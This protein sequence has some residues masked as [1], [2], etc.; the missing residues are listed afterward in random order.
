MRSKRILLVRHAET[1]YN[2]DARMQG[3]DAHTPLTR[4]GIAQAE[5]MGTA[6]A[7]MLG[8]DPAVD[9]WSSPAGRALQT[10]AVIAEHLGRS[11]FD[12]H[13][14][15]RVREIDVGEWRGRRYADIVAEVGPIVC[16]DRRAFDVRFPGG[17]CYP[18]VAARLGAWLGDLPPDRDVLLV[19]HGVA[20]RVLRGLLIGGEP[21]HGVP[22][23]DDAPQGTIFDIADGG[24]TVVAPDR[25]RLGVPAA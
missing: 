18:A 6:L 10:A 5:A 13:T 2:A 23:A 4:R 7:A 21:W 20:A 25:G 24:E 22:L 8:R 12:I 17:E 1:V 16:P 9:L 3:N 14:D 11:F 15:P 19:T